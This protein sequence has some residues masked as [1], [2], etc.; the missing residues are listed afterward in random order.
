MLLPSSSPV[1]DENLFGWLER[2]FLRFL[3]KKDLTAQKSF[4]KF[5]KEGLRCGILPGHGG[6]NTFPETSQLPLF[7]NSFSTSLVMSEKQTFLVP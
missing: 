1:A 6:F 3:A 7:L 4:V 5:Q 2:I